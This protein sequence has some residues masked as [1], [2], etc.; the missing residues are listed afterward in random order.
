MLGSNARTASRKPDDPRSAA[1]AAAE[2]RV[3]SVS[4]LALTARAAGYVTDG[5]V[6][7]AVLCALVLCLATWMFVLARFAPH[8]N[9][10]NSACDLYTLS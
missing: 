1:L 8:R 6:C 10:H 7:S 4:A 9:S 2:A 5:C 3:K